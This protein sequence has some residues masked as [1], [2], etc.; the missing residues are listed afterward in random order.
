VE[1]IARGV[2]AWRERRR[3]RRSVNMRIGLALLAPVALLTLVSAFWT[4]ASPTRTA[5]RERLLGAGSPGHLLGTD[6]LGRDELSMLMAGAMTSFQI[7]I[8]GT[9]FGLLVGVAIGGLSAMIGTFF[10]DALM[11]ACDVLFAFPS[12]ILAMVLAAGMGASKTTVVIAI[13]LTVGPAIARLVRSVTTQ[14]LHRDFIAAARGYGRG[15][16]YI[17]IRHVLPNISSALIVTAATVFASSILT[18]ASL[19]YLGV[20]TQPPGVSWG[21]MLNDAQANVAVQ[22]MLAIWPGL[23]IVICVLGLSLIGDGLRDRFDV[24]GRARL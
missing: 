23:A 21:R 16:T 20:G 22:P 6:H 3:A 19:S 15:R 17:F 1:L 24:K 13:A 4:P 14:V 12:V 18:D 9:A 2:G 5:A 7:A 10:D 8:L 11:R